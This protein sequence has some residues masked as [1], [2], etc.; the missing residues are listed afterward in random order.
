[1]KFSI[2]RTDRTSDLTTIGE[3]CIIDDALWRK[4]YKEMM[5]RF[6]RQE[7]TVFDVDECQEC[8]WISWKHIFAILKWAEE[9]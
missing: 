8:A 4:W 5:T 9:N 3:K 1:M 7:H 6:H 2:H